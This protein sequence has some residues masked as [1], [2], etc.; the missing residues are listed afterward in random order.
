MYKLISDP[1]HAWLE[2]SEQEVKES[3]IPVSSYSYY[4][5]K[6][7]LYYLEEDVD[8]PAFMEAKGLSSNKLVKFPYDT[9]CFVRELPHAA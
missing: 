3:G 7:K 9:D 8:M 4:D 1:G 6:R 5:P 2:V